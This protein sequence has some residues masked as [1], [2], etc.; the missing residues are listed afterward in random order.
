LFDSAKQIG[1][2]A[3][4]VGGSAG[5]GRAGILGGGAAHIVAGLAQTIERLLGGLLAAAGGLIRGLTGG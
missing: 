2:F 4:A 3:Q 5:I 1:G